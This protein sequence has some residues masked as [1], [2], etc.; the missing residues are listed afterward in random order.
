MYL[1]VVGATAFFRN[2]NPSSVFQ[3]QPGDFNILRFR[4]ATARRFLFLGIIF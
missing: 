4:E 1:G 3:S 2:H